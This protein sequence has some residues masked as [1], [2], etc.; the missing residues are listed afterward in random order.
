MRPARTPLLH[1][2]RKVRQGVAPCSPG[3]QPGASLFDLRTGLERWNGRPRTCTP[4]P[5]GARSLSRRRRH[6]R[7]VDRPGVGA[8]SG[9]EPRLARRPR[10][11][12]SPLARLAA[13]G[14]PPLEKTLETPGVAPGT[15]PCRGRVIL[16]H[17]V[18][19]RICPPRSRT[20]T[21]AFR[22]Q[23]PTVG[24]GGIKAARLSRA[25]VGTTELSISA[26]RGRR[27]RLRSSSS[28]A[29]PDVKPRRRCHARR[30]F[31]SSRVRRRRRSLFGAS[32]VGR[33]R[34]D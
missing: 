22:A 1:S 19:V 26:R 24:L 12:W 8:T 4:A 3:L 27:S 11:V 20:S 18:P 31:F 21:S 25:A 17:H 34:S 9:H 30:D 7:P 2:A 23:R 28:F 16:F 33:A 13:A 14:A 10:L 29:P 6:A 15:R 5:R 32:G